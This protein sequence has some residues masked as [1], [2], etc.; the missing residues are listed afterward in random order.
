[1]QFRAVLICGVACAAAFFYLS[2]NLQAQTTGATF[3]DVISLGGTPSDV[4]LDEGRGKL[5]TVNS[6]ANRIDIYDYANQ[7]RAGSIGVGTRPLAAAMSMDGNLLYV[8]NNGSSTVSVVDLNSRGVVQTVTVP[9]KP[10]GVEVGADGRA[11]ICTQGT[12]GTTQNVLYIFDRTQP[13]NQQLQA[14]PFSPPPPTPTGLP[15]VQARPTTTF[16]G[17]LQRTPD[18]N[19][20]VGVSVINNNAQTVAYVYETAS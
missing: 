14:V 8:T 2:I 17:K 13:L 10:E 4:V 6:S 12:G 9:A 18:G 11:L 20:I 3:G 7:Q 19:F 16:R 1:M 5:Y 15:A